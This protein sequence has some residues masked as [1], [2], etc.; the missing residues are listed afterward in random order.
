MTSALSQEVRRARR[1]LSAASCAAATWALPAAAQATERIAV[2]MVSEDVRDVAL[3]ENLAEVAVA[4]LAETRSGEFVGTRELRRLI[5]R[6]YRDKPLASCVYEAPC[7]THLREDLA[8]ALVI[9]GKLHR[10]GTRIVLTL[11][12]LDAASGIEKHQVSRSSDDGVAD[13]VKA[14]QAA[15]S[16]LFAPSAAAEIR[17]AQPPAPAIARPRAAP[18]RAVDSA[19]ILAPT[20][21]AP[22]ESTRWRTVVGYG[23]GA[24]AILTLS[25]AAVVGTLAQQEP[26]G[27]TRREAQADL[28]RGKTLATTA[29]VLWISSGVLAITSAI[30]LIPRSPATHA[31]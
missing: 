10:E 15:V 9:V 5:E 28:E 16:E 18:R 22:P 3:A 26:S 21:V 1:W 24:F 20:P 6:T 25:A 30:A 17:E 29:N 12:L 31:R 19:R 8:V 27:A 13:L 4:K 11:E 23:S 14:T 2:A 7:L